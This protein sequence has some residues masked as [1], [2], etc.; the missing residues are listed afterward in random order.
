MFG[1]LGAFV[2]NGQPHYLRTEKS[3]LLCKTKFS[4]PET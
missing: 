4:T 1:L 3:S 2:H